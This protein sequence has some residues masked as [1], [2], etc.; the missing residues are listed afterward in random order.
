MPQKVQDDKA[1]LLYQKLTETF[2][3]SHYQAKSIISS[4]PPAYIE[5]TLA[6][7][8]TKRAE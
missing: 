7:V 8:K 6:I 4:Y 3:L 2:K 1:S 5:E